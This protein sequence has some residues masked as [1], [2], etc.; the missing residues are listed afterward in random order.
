MAKDSKAGEDEGTHLADRYYAVGLGADYGAL[1]GALTF[2]MQDY[3]GISG[4]K[5]AGT[6]GEVDQVNDGEY[7]DSDGYAVTAFGAYDFGVTKVSLGAQYFDNVA[8][9]R[10]SVVSTFDGKTGD[11]KWGK[12]DFGL[13][14]YGV[15]LGAITPIAGGNLYTSL[16]YADYEA[17]DLPDGHAADVK[18]S[19]HKAYGVGVGYQYPLSKRTYVYTAASYTHETSNAGE[20]TSKDLDTD[21]TEVMM[22][23]VH[24]F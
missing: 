5:T 10:G 17:A 7:N 9:T 2:S 16:G 1:K 18:K 8:Q 4:R 13:T 22:G 11:A 6:G 12:V 20:A 21:T 23:L 14:G 15:I 24:N 3:A 19:D